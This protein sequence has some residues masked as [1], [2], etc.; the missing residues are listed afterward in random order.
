MKGAQVSYSVWPCCVV[1]SSELWYLQIL[2]SLAL[3]P[4]FP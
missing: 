2:K 3:L 1:L 4:Q